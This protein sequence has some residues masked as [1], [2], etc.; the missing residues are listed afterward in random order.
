MI[1]KIKTLIKRLI[2][3]IPKE[4]RPIILAA[5]G[6]LLMCVILLSSFFDAGKNEIKDTKSDTETYEENGYVSE[7]ER[8][9]TDI[10]S[11]IEGAGRV[12]VM[13]TLENSEENVYAVDI[14]ESKNEYV[15]IKT[16]SDEGGLLLKIIQPKIR[17]V[18]IVCDGGEISKVK[19]RILDAACSAMGISSSKVSISKMENQEVTYE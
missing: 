1:D 14:N 2:E 19:M 8:K 5:G 7:L 6:V 18:A 16:S 13:I 11:S 10:I 3:K 12:K 9:L 15:L 17:G 4:K